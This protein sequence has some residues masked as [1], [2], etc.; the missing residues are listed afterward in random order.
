[1]FDYVFEILKQTNQLDKYKSI[2][3]NLLIP[4]DGT[5]YFSSNTIHCN[6]CSIKQHKNGTTSYSHS[7]ITP[8]IVSPNHNNV[9]S[10]EPEFIVPQD[11]HKKQDCENVAAKRWILKYSK[12]YNEIGTTQ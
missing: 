12:R 2:N 6:K 4:L 8:V 5:G 7:V 10:L 1:M 3:D 11:G 9:I